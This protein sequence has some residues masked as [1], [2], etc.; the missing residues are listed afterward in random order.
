MTDWDQIGA[1]GNLARLT[2]QARLAKEQAAR[3]AQLAA[4]NREIASLLKEQKQRADEEEKRLN[5]MPKCPDCR[6]PVE[7][8]SR[9]CPHCHIEIISWDYSRA[10]MAWRLFCRA[11]EAGTRL[12]KRCDELLR[13]VAVHR[14]QCVQCLDLQLRCEAACSHVWNI[15]RKYNPES[16][17]L[18]RELLSQALTNS[19]MATPKDKAALREIWLRVE[20]LPVPTDAPGSGGLAETERRQSLRKAKAAAEAEYRKKVEAIDKSWRSKLEANGLLPAL[21]ELDRLRTSGH[22]IRSRT[23]QYLKNIQSTLKALDA[24][25][26]FAESIGVTL[27]APAIKDP[28]DLSRLAKTPVPLPTIQF[29]VAEVIAGEGKGILLTAQSFE[30]VRHFLQSLPSSA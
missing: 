21:R 18:I 10:G 9:R 14:D 1:M 25:W 6:K 17:S 24:T 4:Q 23:D 19:T 29:K 22:T 30:A 27:R 3:D 5:A 13:D 28:R 16:Q 26:R 12:Q 15:V 7:L 11:S 8:G 2:Q 20:S